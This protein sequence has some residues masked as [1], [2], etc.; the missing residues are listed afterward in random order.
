MTLRAPR[1]QATRTYEEAI[2]VLILA[3]DSIKAQDSEWI[4]FSQTGA[5]RLGSM[6][7]LIAYLYDVEYSQVVKDVRLARRKERRSNGNPIQ[8]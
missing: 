4:G 3:D 6:F 7:E 5:A 2:E 8:R 1:Y